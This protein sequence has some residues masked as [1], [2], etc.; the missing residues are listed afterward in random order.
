MEFMKLS[1]NSEKNIMQQSIGLQH[2]LIDVT[3][4]N[5]WQGYN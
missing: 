1:Q 2:I 3:V 4:L 5:P